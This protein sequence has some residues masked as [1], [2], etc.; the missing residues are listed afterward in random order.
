MLSQTLLAAAAMH[1]E[2]LTPVAGLVPVRPVRCAVSQV[3]EEREQ[4]ESLQSGLTREA[5]ATRTLRVRTPAR[6]S[7]V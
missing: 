3:L 2:N 1:L 4:H 5:W 7:N 6:A